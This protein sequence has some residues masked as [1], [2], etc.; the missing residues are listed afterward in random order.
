MSGQSDIGKG[1]P[2]TTAEMTYPHA[3]TY[4]GWAFGEIW[5]IDEGINQGYPYFGEMN[6]LGIFAKHKGEWREVD[7]WAKHKGEWR[8][9]NGAWGNKQEW[10]GI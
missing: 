7:A 8:E 9:V 3:N 2:R 5:V 1:E 4:V 6:V 10:K